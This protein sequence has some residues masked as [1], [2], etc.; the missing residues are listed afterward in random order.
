MQ[1]AVV[2]RLRRP[3]RRK[4][5]SSERLRRLGV[6]PRVLTSATGAKRTGH[7]R[8][9]VP[10]V[11]TACCLI[12]VR[13]LPC[14]PSVTCLLPVFALT[15]GAACPHCFRSAV[16]EWVRQLD[17]GCPA[18]AAVDA[19][20]QGCAHTHRYRPGP[21][22]ARRACGRCRPAARHCAMP[23]DAAPL[24]QA[25]S[26]FQ[27]TYIPHGVTAIQA[28][29]V[30]GTQPKRQQPAG[31]LAA[32]VA[33]ARAGV[34]LKLRR[35]PTQLTGFDEAASLG[36]SLFQARAPVEG[37]PGSGAG[38]PRASSPFV[39]A[40]LFGDGDPPPHRFGELAHSQSSNSLLRATLQRSM[41]SNSQMGAASN[42]TPAGE[43]SLH[44]GLMSPRSTLVPRHVGAG[45]PRSSSMLT[46]DTLR[47]ASAGDLTSS[48]QDVRNGPL[49]RSSSTLGTH[50]LGVGGESHGSVN[51]LSASLQG[52]SL[53]GDPAAHGGSFA[54]DTVG[55]LPRVSSRQ[56]FATA[57]SHAASHAMVTPTV[58]EEG[59]SG[60]QYA[61]AGEP[62]QYSGQ[63]G[64]FATPYGEHQLPR[65]G[66][67][68]APPMFIPHAQPPGCYAAALL[69]M[70]IAQMAQLGLPV[71]DPADGMQPGLLPHAFP[72]PA[73]GPGM[74]H[75]GMGYY[76]TPP[77]FPLA[78]P[79]SPMESVD[80]AFYAAYFQRLMEIQAMTG[81]A[82]A[83]AAMAASMGGYPGFGA[84][85]YGGP[86]GLDGSMAPGMLGGP[87]YGMG[88][89]Y[90]PN[91]GGLGYGGDHRRERER[92]PRS[93]LLDEFKNNKSFKFELRDLVGHAAEFAQDQ[94]G[95]RFIQQKLET[96]CSW[97]QRR[98]RV[99]KFANAYRRRR[100][101]KTWLR[102]SRKS[103]P[104]RPG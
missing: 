14:D 79:Y 15:A 77:M 9:A 75:R 67:G 26:C 37:A 99:P 73:P 101:L 25:P 89:G 69:Q 36:S 10:D 51:D 64:D 55:P 95:S 90:H 28:K 33:H 70:Q 24:P 100:L 93:T 43:D 59:I 54:E 96:V 6:I 58:E 65:G 30:G 5:L 20:C 22:V 85:A 3:K 61:A 2:P 71:G 11:G 92:G 23:A 81:G 86:R 78:S 52:F 47:S 60:V 8:R 29:R 21:A 42:Q 57:P 19:A 72:P 27:P 12:T 44:A 32:R 63:F 4:P 13:S 98:A 38:S 39:H 53:A 82:A 87:F 94:H 76:S 83:A 16:V 56:A 41:S 1:L 7:C 34:K 49:T 35:F 45:S 80:P 102:C 48:L 18:Q 97:Q 50:A 68:P 104:P 74:P 31:A 88:G 40:T 84:P 62:Q 46:F 66:P 17:A 91:A 103:C